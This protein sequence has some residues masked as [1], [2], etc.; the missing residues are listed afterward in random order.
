MPRTEQKYTNRLLLALVAVLAI[1]QGGCLLIL[2][3]VAGGATAGYFYC[4]GRISRDYP[5]QLVDVHHAV[6]AALLDLHFLVFND[7][8]K[9]GKAFLLTKTTS[10][11]KVRIY[12][13]SLNSP[14]PA[15]GIITR[16]SIRVACFG[17]E[18]ISKRILHQ[19]ALHLVPG[20][21]VVPAPPPAPTPVQPTSATRFETTPPPLAPPKPIQSK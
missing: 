18:E 11:K 5:A 13:N 3:G 7:E 4:K 10:G 19:I 8:V 2:A 12:L 15:E 9:D 14:I 6:H 1:A 17:D 21:A 20:P 16:V